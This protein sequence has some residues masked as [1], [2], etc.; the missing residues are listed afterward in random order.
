MAQNKETLKEVKALAS[1]EL[2]CIKI[3]EGDIVVPL[4]PMYAGDV[5]QGIRMELS[6]MSSRYSKELGGIPM[7]YEK[8][9]VSPDGG[10]IHTN[11]FIHFRVQATFYVFS[12]EVGSQL[13]G[14]VKRKSPNHL[15]CLIHKIFSVSV[16]RPHSALNWPGDSLEEG[17]PVKLIVTNV[18]MSF[19]L[20][21]ITAQLDPSFVPDKEKASSSKNNEEMQGGN[22]RNI[23]EDSGIS[24]ESEEKWE[25][26][27][28]YEERNDNENEENLVL[29]KKIKKEKEEEEADDDYVN[30]KEKIKIDKKSEKTKRSK[31]A[32]KDKKSKKEKK[33]DKDEDLTK[34]K[35]KK[36]KRLEEYSQEELNK[37]TKKEK[38]KK[39]DKERVKERSDNEM[40]SEMPSESSANFSSYLMTVPKEESGDFDDSAFGV[41]NP[42]NIKKFAKRP[43]SKRMN[44]IESNMNIS[45]CMVKIK[46]EKDVE[47]HNKIELVSPCIKSPKSKKRKLELNIK[48]E[49]DDDDDNRVESI[50]PR[51]KSPKSKKRKLE[52]SSHLI[53]K[54]IK[55]E[56][57]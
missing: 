25:N 41:K 42:R 51:I 16:P 27:K 17:D 20:P 36:E 40:D 18:N 49:K 5:S 28:D 37:E 15:G 45:K 4:H 56:K 54:E 31:K 53:K 38:G 13:E 52:F 22:S 46:V 12:P 11:P 1:N 24:S 33:E 55:V 26:K 29:N 6:A 19:Y 23:G 32:K 9:K 44:N 3:R 10:V 47:N 35:K 57:L 50:S 48:V 39:K 34:Y 7:A 21:M 2:S 14:S 8:V 43:E 30:E